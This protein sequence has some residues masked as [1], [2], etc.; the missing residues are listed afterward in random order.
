MNRVTIVAKACGSEEAPE[1]TLEALQSAVRA[2]FPPWARLAIEVDLRLTA[3]GAFVAFHDATL[4]RTTDGRGPVRSQSVSALKRLRAGPADERIPTLDEVLGAGFAGDLILDVH[5][6]S[7]EALRRLLEKMRQIPA[8]TTERIIVASEHAR[9]VHGVRNALPRVRTS[10][11][12][13]EAWRKLVCGWL[14]LK[15]SLGHGR[16]YMVPLAHR[17]LR[18]V[19]RRF[20]RGT[21]AGPADVWAYGLSEPE[22]VLA[23]RAIGVTGCFSTRP[24]AFGAALLRTS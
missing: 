14:G 15:V 20:V 12:P 18:V 24:R 3:D 8:E 13:A 6:P 19:T 22:Q 17:G 11:T 16:I 21:A 9:V 10:A 5:D 1:N 23:L 2:D 4:E 7:D